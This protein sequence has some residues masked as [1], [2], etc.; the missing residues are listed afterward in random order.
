[1]QYSSPELRD[2][3]GER[4]G[5]VHW[6]A[7]NYYAAVDIGPVTREVYYTLPPDVRKAFSKDGIRLSTL[8]NELD[9]SV[10]ENY[11]STLMKHEKGLEE[12]GVD[13][14]TLRTNLLATP[15]TD[16]TQNADKNTVKPKRPKMKESAKP[17][18]ETQ[19]V[20][21]KR[22]KPKMK[23]K[24]K[25]KCTKKKPDNKETLNEKRKRPAD[26]P[27][28]DDPAEPAKKRKRAPAKHKPPNKEQGNEKRE[29]PV[30]QKKPDNKE[31]L[32]ENGKRPADNPED[33]PAEPAK[34]K[35]KNTK[36]L[37]FIGQATVAQIGRALEMNDANYDAW[38][39]LGNEGG[40]DVC[41]KTYS[42]KDCYERALE[43]NDANHHAWN[44][45]G[46]VGGGQVNGTRCTKK[47]CCI[48]AIKLGPPNDKAMY[49]AWFNLG[50]TGGGT[51]EGT[52]YS[53][54]DCYIRA[55]ELN[56]KCHVAWCHLGCQGGGTVND[57]PYSSHGCYIKALEIGFQHDEAWVKLG[58]EGGGVVNGKPYSKKQ[59]YEKAVNASEGLNLEAWVKLGD[60]GGGTV[61]VDGT[62]LEL[63]REECYTWVI[64]RDDEHVD[65]WYKIGCETE[66]TEYKTKCFVKVLEIDENHAKA[67]KCLGDVAFRLPQD[68]VDVNN[69]R[70]TKV[71][72]YIQALQIHP[73]KEA[74]HLV[75]FYGGGVVNDTE[76]SR[77][78]CYSKI[79]EMDPSD[80]DAWDALGDA[81]GDCDEDDP[82]A[83]VNGYSS[84]KCYDNA[85][86]LRKGG[87]IKGWIAEEVTD[88]GEDE[89]PPEKESEDK[90]PTELVLN[91]DNAALIEGE[92]HAPSLPAPPH[93][94]REH[95]WHEMDFAKQL[96]TIAE[97][98]VGKMGDRELPDHLRSE[99][100]EGQIALTSEQVR[101]FFKKACA[102]DPNGPKAGIDNI[103]NALT[104]PDCRV[105]LLDLSGNHDE[106][107]FCSGMTQAKLCQLETYL[108]EG[109]KKRLHSFSSLLYLVIEERNV[110]L[111]EEWEKDTEARKWWTGFGDK[112]S[113]PGCILGHL[114]VDDPNIGALT[115]DIKSSIERALLLNRCKPKYKEIAD[116]HPQAYREQQ[117]CLEEKLRLKCEFR[118]T[119][120]LT[121]NLDGFLDYI[122]RNDDDSV[123]FQVIVGDQNI[124]DIVSKINGAFEKKF[125]GLKECFIDTMN[126][127]QGILEN[128]MKDQ[129][130]DAERNLVIL[131]NAMKKQMKDAERDLVAAVPVW[132]MRSWLTLSDLHKNA[133]FQKLKDDSPKASFVLVTGPTHRN[134]K[135]I[136]ELTPELCDNVIGKSEPV[137]PPPCLI[138]QAHLDQAF[139]DACPDLPL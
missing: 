9:P 118:E 84:V 119:K 52:Q 8:Q 62:P 6:G 91:E 69:T 100:A 50:C 135:N 125:N 139:E 59:C 31:T 61:N 27:E 39:K 114:D 5:C 82:N 112:L 92:D 96:K 89:K 70:Y 93:P 44:K 57:Q 56:S 34:K 25:R 55:I 42:R 77:V 23:A 88:E 124:H 3:C 86:T 30:E 43:I 81:L 68:A 65:A 21:P 74:W 67:W 32:N 102:T 2:T 113:E 46:T 80:P 41:G 115:E 123:Q 111:R 76:Y 98:G 7:C 120:F 40:G 28:E 78:E 104:H 53:E 4:S 108:L 129:M 13:V 16:K 18:K 63:D 37:Q 101:A 45:L 71:G 66:N 137:P 12:A 126:G 22:P 138:D 38:V 133:T 33:D 109:I 54:Q 29:I 58:E 128:A 95:S 85:N 11:I 134:K 105:V 94:E 19:K 79:V 75:G 107:P 48:K 99:L 35:R 17:N 72:C 127:T 121:A 90:D 106:W 131:E 20:K 73:D 49:D 117:Q 122:T 97:G 10:Y 110:W 15:A 132:D 130:N 83:T 64:D 136:I 47:D 26:K 51:V 24:A 87:A 36:N 14:E 116:G 103:L 1:M 60:E